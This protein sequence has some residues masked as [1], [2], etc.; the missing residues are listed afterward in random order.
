MPPASSHCSPDVCSL[1][2]VGDQGCEGRW[3]DPKDAT[4]QS[5]SKLSPQ[6]QPPEQLPPEWLNFRDTVAFR[7]KISLLSPGGIVGRL[8]S[9]NQI[10]NRAG[11]ENRSRTSVSF[12]NSRLSFIHTHSL[13]SEQPQKVCSVPDA[14]LVPGIQS[15]V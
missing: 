14:T 13:I 15:L 3:A 11:G 5:C 6:G 9:K 4:L 1:P 7:E 10:Q 12:R 8:M 2:G